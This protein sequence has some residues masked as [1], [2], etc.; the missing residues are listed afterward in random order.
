MKVPLKNLPMNNAGAGQKLIGADGPDGFEFFCPACAHS[1]ALRLLNFKSIVDEPLGQASD[2][3]GNVKREFTLA[4][5]CFCA[6]CGF[7][8]FVKV[9]NLGARSPGLQIAAEKTS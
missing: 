4:L 8:D 6:E 9:S 3:R 2:G 5:E 7:H 1:P